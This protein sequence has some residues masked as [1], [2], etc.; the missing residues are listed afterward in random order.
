MGDGWLS[1]EPVKG[2]E[3]RK[4]EID[5]RSAKFPLSTITGTL[6]NSSTGLAV[7]FLETSVHTHSGRLGNSVILAS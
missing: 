7:S 4:K 5:S 1:R 3:R 2:G 6:A